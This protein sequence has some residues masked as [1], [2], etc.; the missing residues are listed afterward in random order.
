MKLTVKQISDLRS[1]KYDKLP[2]NLKGWSL[3]YDQ[4]TGEFDSEKGAMYDFEVYLYDEEGNMRY[5]GIGGWSHQGVDFYEDIE[6]EDISNRVETETYDLTDLEVR[7]IAAMAQFISDGNIGAEVIEGYEDLT[8]EEAW[9][10]LQL[11]KSK[12]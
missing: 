10:G 5:E 1:G 12:F 7:T 11:I 4:S 9:E 3:D 8:S 2:E 6:F